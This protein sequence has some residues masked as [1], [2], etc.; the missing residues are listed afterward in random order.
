MN[1][2][3]VYLPIFVS[4]KSLPRHIVQIVN[5]CPGVDYQV[6][7]SAGKTTTGGQV[8]ATL[9]VNGVPLAGGVISSELFMLR[10]ASVGGAIFSSTSNM[11]LVQILT[12][13]GGTGATTEVHVELEDVDGSTK[14]VMTHRGIPADSPGAAG[15]V[16]AFNKLA[17][18]VGSGA[19]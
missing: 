15:W 3:F 19:T 2:V 7:L 4:R 1:L 18:Q 5:I 13:A 10:V 9:Y 11:A 16:M 17:A 6:G 8:S 12:Y 14:M